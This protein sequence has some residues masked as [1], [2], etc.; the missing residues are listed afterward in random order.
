[1][2]VKIVLKRSSILDKRPNADL[3]DPGELALNTNALSPG[4]F[5][6]TDNNQVA[7]VGPTAV[8]VVPPTLF[9]SLG[10]TFF[11]S[12]TKELSVGAID[13]E[14]ASQVWSKV[15]APYLGGTD[16]YVVFVASEF[17]SASDSVDNNGQAAPYKTLN[18][19][20][21]EI[22][23]H[24]IVTQNES[25]EGKNNRFVIYVAPGICPV[26]NGPGLPV[27]I[28]TNPD[29][30]PEFSVNFDGTPASQPDVLSLQQFNPVTGG[31]L[32]PRGTSII[33]MDLR[34]TQ[35]RPSYVPTYKNP[36]T[37]VGT[38][39]TRSSI[40]KWTGNSIVN[41]LSFRDKREVVRIDNIKTGLA[42]E[43]L[44]ISSRPHCFDLDDQVT[45]EFSP[46]AD[47]RPI[48][49][50]S[51]AVLAG[52][53]FV[54][55][56]GPNSFYLSYTSITAGEPNYVER[57]QLPAAPQGVAFI[58]TCYWEGRSHN[59]LS[60]LS[61]ASKS[62]LNE[63][64]TKVQLAFPDF[65]LGKINQAEVINP[66]ETEI[67]GPVPP[68]LQQS[69][70]SNTN[71]NASPYVDNVSVRSNFGLCG[72]E[73]DGVVV[74][75][76]RSALA[77][78]FT[79]ASL[80]NDPVAY[81]IYTTIQDPSSAKVETKWFNLQY[82]AWA[83]L[84]AAVRPADPSFVT[85]AQQLALLNSTEVTNVR[86]YYTTLK[87]LDGK[88][89]GLPDLENDFRHFSIRSS[90]NAYVQ[91]DTSYSIGCAV[92]YW[93][94]YGGRMTVT[95]S[96][97]N[98]GLN[99][100]R[101]EGFD[102]IGG[103][104]F[105]GSAQQRGT[106]FVFQGIRM[107]DKLTPR[108][109]INYKTSE[110]GCSV[111]SVTNV[112]GGVQEIA[113]GPGFSPINILPYALEPGTA[114]Y[115]NG[116]GNTV[117]RAFFVDDGKPTVIF[118]AAG[119][120]GSAIFRVR[121]ID[122][123]FPPGGAETNPDI[124]N[125]S[126][127]F[128]RRWLDPRT[129]EESSYSLIFENSNPSHTPITPG[130]ILQLNQST[131]V[132]SLVLRPGVQFDPGPS[133]G[134]GRVFQVAFSETQELGD[135]PALNEV[136]LNRNFANTYYSSLLLADSANPW[137]ENRDH[138]HG[139]YVTFDER[140]WYAAAND[141]WNGV[142]Y[143]IAEKATGELK[144][145]PPQNESPWAT[146]FS[147]E[148]QETVE[149]AYQGAYAP[150]PSRDLYPKG[151]YFR[152]D[153]WAIDNYG[154][155]LYY[156]KDNGTQNF[157]LLRN[158]TPTAVVK[159]LTQSLTPTQTVAYVDNVT[160]I[161]SPFKTFV[162]MNIA[163]PTQSEYVQVVGIDT[164]TN[165][166]TLIRGLYGSTVNSNFDVNDPLTLQQETQEVLASEYDYDWA[167]SKSAMTR[168]LQ[169]MGY[170]QSDITTL[171]QPRFRSYR[172]VYLADLAIKPSQ[173]GGYAITT[174][175][176][177][178][179]FIRP[180]QLDAVSHSF[181]SVGRLDY[182][183]GLPQYVRNEVNIKQYYDY[184]STAIWGGSLTVSGAD[185]LGHFLTTG[186][187]TQAET[188][189][190]IGNYTSDIKNATRVDPG[191]GEG[192]G[193]GGGDGVSAVY[194]GTGLTGGPIFAEGTISL[195]PPT[196]GQI[197]GVKA[198]ANIT[199]SADGTISSQAG[200]AGTVTSITFGTG[201]SGGTI[202]TTGTVGINVGTGLIIDTSNKLTLKPGTVSEIG[203]VKAGTATSISPEGAISVLPP[204]G[205]LIGGVKQGAGVTIAS[206]GTISVNDTPSAGIVLID[207]ISPVFNG[208]QNQF[209][210]TVG[211]KPYTPTNSESALITVG[212][213]PQPTPSAY[214]ISGSTITFSS[215]PPGGSSFYGLG[216]DGTIQS[217]LAAGI[218]V[219][220]LDDI[221]SQF[222]GTAKQFTLK[223]AGTP[224][225]PVASYYALITLGGVVQQ[226][227]DSYSITGST[228]T[229]TEAP[230]AGTTFYGIAFG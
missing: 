91:V 165:A 194:T 66:G 172:N 215:P 82:A 134:W 112:T 80:Q 138:D 17:P 15:A 209:S 197:G 104:S 41:T 226:T 139:T 87:A 182:S 125:W 168:F 212:N 229:F 137:S 152:G 30:V 81:Q 186:E 116:R 142:Y 111:A 96:S 101:S 128:I 123:T 184:L 79:V 69:L 7:K 196:A 190:P 62:E 14:T 195:V 100:L 133:G 34:K 18:R 179:D 154:F 57:T 113:V 58:A 8:G 44:F 149:S 68:S 170:T 31:L 216:F 217:L 95:N 77:S 50:N 33:G 89:F 9:P 105:E 114:I 161:P 145:A 107:P 60:C 48:S 155:D 51:A 2:A 127:P 32:V 151:A 27:P 163:N 175:P 46:G 173:N 162:V 25:D 221:S 147:S 5:F 129:I 99:A 108:D 122:S 130:A 36:T 63:F 3:L 198:G 223:Q 201:L 208:I 71:E 40:L 39:Q 189:R 199:I 97:S 54:Y 52:T 219:I 35:L 153:T 192:G 85:K 92:G 56:V 61:A 191:P 176:W 143:N 174:G 28:D 200:G 13:T 21:I 103:T 213:V 1:M 188:G 157:G 167:M 98:F 76:F 224:Y 90:N 207:D 49:N 115:V 218:A 72:L 185:E 158:T 19:A 74:S 159:T 67:V 203:G 214:T 132:S 10:E 180:S 118:T 144:L 220:K 210:L 42:G 146:S 140:N 65:F 106:G 177:P 119:C 126:N 37:G 206:D 193:G 64:Y 109:T 70:L 228:I 38:N 141:L 83:L 204:S 121:A 4:L 26:Y 110:L 178:I 227:P 120:G 102:G 160:D 171:L 94:I 78:S 16:G 45:F 59:R 124:L 156:N 73:Q 47:S 136:L 135:S 205:P 86:Y 169:V 230:V 29:N 222:N 93:S 11:D 24:S 164:A 55:P 166:L 183:R 202:T 20:I 84:P 181:H 211:G 12:V 22:A 53:Y 117:Y 43:G 150:D 225:S 88:S 6:E 187:F 75:G 23:K 131:N 148:L